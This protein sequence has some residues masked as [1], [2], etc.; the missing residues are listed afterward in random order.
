MITVGN[1]IPEDSKRHQHAK[2]KF[3]SIP[4]LKS[5]ELSHGSEIE[6]VDISREGMV[7]ETDTRLRPDF[8]VVLKIVTGKG[9]MRVPGVVLRS[10]ICS[11]T[12]GPRY[13]SAVE[14]TRPLEVLD[15]AMIPAPATARIED[16]AAQSNAEVDPT[17]TPAVLTVWQAATVTSS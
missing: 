1:N 7:L 2:L 9:P 12:G 5:V 11:L 10:A 14:F 6:I 4:G 3:E 15:E 13:R 8:K 16:P 17:K